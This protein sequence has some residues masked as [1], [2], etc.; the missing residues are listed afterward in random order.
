MSLSEA[1]LGAIDGLKKMVASCYFFLFIIIIIIV[2]SMTSIIIAIIYTNENPMVCLL[3]LWVSKCF[4][5]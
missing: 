3:A 2:L 4:F 1:K 5:P